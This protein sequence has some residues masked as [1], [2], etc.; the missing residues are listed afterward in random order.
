MTISKTTTKIPIVKKNID[1]SDIQLYTI[2][3]IVN[4]DSEYKYVGLYLLNDLINK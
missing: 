4:N 2:S 3:K 1:F